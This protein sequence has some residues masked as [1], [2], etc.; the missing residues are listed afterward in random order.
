MLTE[1]ETVLVV[2]SNTKN[3]IEKFQKKTVRIGNFQKKKLLKSI[4]LILQ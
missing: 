1:L 4:F 3:K 2:P